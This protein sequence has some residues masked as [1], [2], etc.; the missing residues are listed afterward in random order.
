MLN[1]RHKLF[2]NESPVNHSLIF[3]HGCGMDQI[4]MIQKYV[5][6]IAK[7]NSAELI[8][9]FHYSEKFLLGCSVVTLWLD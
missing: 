2:D 4:F 7:W 9:A 6:F 8:E 1:I 3:N 5:Y